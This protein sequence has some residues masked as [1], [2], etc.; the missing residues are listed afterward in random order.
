MDSM[1]LNK[2]LSYG[3]LVIAVGFLAFGGWL[4]AAARRDERRLSFAVLVAASGLWLLS[5]VMWRVAVDDSAALFW[6]R[7][8]HV[9]GITLPLA[10]LALALSCFMAGRPRLPMAVGSFVVIAVSAWMAFSFDGGMS[11]TV[12]GAAAPGTN[13]TLLAA[14]FAAAFTASLLAF[15]LSSRRYRAREDGRSVTALLIG[16]VIAL[17]SVFSVLYSFSV[18][19]NVPDYGWT[20][21][22]FTAGILIMAVFLLQK[23]L[24]V[25]LRFV[26]MEAVILLA[27]LI[28]MTDIVA[29]AE[30]A[31][32]LYFR[33]TVLF[34]LGVYGFFATRAMV[35][36]AR[37]HRQNELLR[38]QVI[39]TNRQ[40]IEADR[41]KTKFVSFVAHQLRTPISGVFIYLDMAKQ[42]RFGELPEDL[43]EIINTNLDVLN[44]MSITVDTFLDLAKIEHGK[45]ELYKTENDVGSL[46]VRLAEAARPIAERKGL[47]IKVGSAPQTLSAVFDNS[48]IYHALFNL[49]DNAIKYTE[50]GSV[51]VSA[52]RLGNLLEFSVRDTGAGLSDDDRQGLFKIFERGVTAVRL[53]SKGAGLGLFIAKQ[54]VEAHGGQVFFDSRGPGQGSTFGFRIPIGSE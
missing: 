52:A 32:E 44:R 3:S 13:R 33:V 42:G 54:F 1:L 23:K 27:T 22:I 37:Q 36:D 25:D 28:L 35:N 39:A 7:M 30:S 12:L 9:V 29:T 45:I 20:V 49:T 19:R 53:E 46:V 10:L 24:L 16:G 14:V 8:M 5:F 48:L 21:V 47:E 17:N 18:P 26:G 15:V 41:F 43:K 6:G 11:F 2:I 4:A 51:T 34:L 50:K 31:I 38:E 40:L